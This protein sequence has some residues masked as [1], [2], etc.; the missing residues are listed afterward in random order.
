MQL[1][2]V[3]AAKLLFEKLFLRV[4]NEIG[5]MYERLHALYCEELFV[6]VP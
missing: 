1:S 6:K 5:M 4:K 2:C 3:S